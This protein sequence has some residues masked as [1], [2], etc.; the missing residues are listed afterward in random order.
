MREE[1]NPL[2]KSCGTRPDSS[3]LISGRDDPAAKTESMV[4]HA[5]SDADGTSLNRPVVR[6]NF[7]GNSAR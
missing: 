6:V 2:I 4:L 3:R 1:F 5:N 7:D